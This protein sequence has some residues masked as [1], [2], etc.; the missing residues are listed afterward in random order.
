MQIFDDPESK[1]RDAEAV[2]SGCRI[3]FEIHG[4]AGER[5]WKDWMGKDEGAIGAGWC[6]QRGVLETAYGRRWYFSWP[7]WIRVSGLQGEPEDFEVGKLYE[8]KP[9]LYFRRLY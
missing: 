7:P 9:N 2:D 3:A 8:A 6:D 4:D 5:S 1:Q